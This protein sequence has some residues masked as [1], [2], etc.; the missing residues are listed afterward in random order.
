[1]NYFLLTGCGI[2]GRV[3]RF[4]LTT[5]S[6]VQFQVTSCEIYG[7]W[8]DTETGFLPCPPVFSL[9]IVILPLLHT[10]LSLPSAAITR[11]HIVSSL[12]IKLRASSLTQHLAGYRVRKLFF[13][14]SWWKVKE[15]MMS[16][17]SN[18]EIDL[19]EI[20]C[21]IVHMNR[22]RCFLYRRLQHRKGPW[23]RSVSQFHHMEARPLYSIQHKPQAPSTHRTWVP[24]STDN[25]NFPRS[26]LQNNA[27][28]CRSI[29]QRSLYF[30]CPIKEH[31]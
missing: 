28:S 6:Q 4:L 14:T 18:I 10:H 22:H 15:D 2:V 13:F 25:W 8:S 20:S 24:F 17:D 29:M 1:M 27:G 19:I 5:E 16:L 30:L 7:G 31:Y 12:V 21:M 3:R 11:Q 26:S 23:I 9:L